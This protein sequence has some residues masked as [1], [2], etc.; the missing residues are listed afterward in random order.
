M[1]ACLA[2]AALV[3]GPIDEQ[4]VALQLTYNTET[5]EEVP[6]GIALSQAALGSF[7]GLAVDL[8]WY[9]ATQLKQDGKYREANE[10]S[11]WICLLQPRFEK[12][13]VFHAWNMSYNISVAT[14][15]PRER[16]QWVNKGI[17]LLRDQALDA[18]PSSVLIKKELGW[19]F[20]HKIGAMS[21]DQHWYYR[22]RLAEEWQILLGSPE[23]LTGEE[24][25]AR[26]LKV[27]EAPDDLKILRQDTTV[28]E[29]LD[30]LATLGYEPDERL[31]VA[32]G[33]IQLY[34]GL[35][36][37]PRLVP[38]MEGPLAEGLPALV[39]Y[40]RKLVLTGRY[41]M[42]PARMHELMERFGPLDWRH[43][44]AHS[45]Y[46]SQLGIDAAARTRRKKDIDQ[47]NTDRLIIHS[48][49]TLTGTGRLSFDPFSDVV[50]MLPDPRFI[51]SYE[52]ALEAG[53]ARI[54]SEEWGKGTKDSYDSGHENFVTRAM[55]LS[56]MYGD[57]A[58]AREYFE[59]WRREYRELHHNRKRRDMTLRE[60]VLDEMENADLFENKSGFIDAMLRRAYIEGMARNRQ[61]VFNRYFSMAKEA[62]ENHQASKN[63]VAAAAR[64]RMKLVTFEE[65]RRTV[66][67][68]IMVDPRVPILYRHR[69]WRRSPLEHRLDVY[70]DVRDIV[71]EHA[72]A[73]GLK[74]EVVLPEPKETEEQR[75]ARELKRQQQ[76]RD[77]GKLL[78]EGK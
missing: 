23:G 27:A 1:A 2:G 77:T 53:I 26:I 73:Q 58:Q 9:R 24:A 25:I 30:H 55:W 20:F 43:P 29:L 48:M 66:Y 63:T 34:R 18:N 70:E 74:P 32:I 47:L 15:T 17:R 38:V 3:S 68:S 78:I 39:A 7:R 10:L 69:I 46:W 4:R 49:Q 72:K 65:R 31:L 45:A 37:D 19:I 41:N 8:M 44:V 71:H 67:R 51:K 62:H 5:G 64:D 36:G 60:L 33:R 54:E 40:L 76:Q 75:R 22:S 57:E 50:D 6:P 12:V 28:A 35:R 52:R 61:D 59:Q 16:W 13:W 42:D 56:Y 21:D 11:Q 14:H